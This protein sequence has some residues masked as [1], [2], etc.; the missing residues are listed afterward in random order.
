MAGFPLRYL[1]TSQQ[2]LGS[3]PVLVFIRDKQYAALNEVQ[4]I[5]LTDNITRFYK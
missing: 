5:I 4:F 1:L 3:V 2:I